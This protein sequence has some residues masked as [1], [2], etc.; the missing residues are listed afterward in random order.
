M[1]NENAKSAGLSNISF[2][3]ASIASIPLQDSSIDCIISNCVINLVPRKD[4]A[5]LFQE[6]SRLLKPGGRVTIS[7]IL[8]KKELPQSILDDMAL[9]VGCIS[10]ASQVME[11]EEYL[12]RAGF[13][14]I[15]P[16]PPRDDLLLTRLQMF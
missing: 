2:I 12:Q 1:A 7:D 14:G 10:G 11:Y 6:I 13:E 5:Y 16:L 3:E 8:A 15:F 4:K 9:Y